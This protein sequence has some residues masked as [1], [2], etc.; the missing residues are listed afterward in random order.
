LLAILPD[1]PARRFVLDAP[2][3]R[4][5]FGFWISVAAFFFNWHR[6]ALDQSFGLNWDVL[7]S[8]SIEEQFYFLYPLLLVVCANRRRLVA[9]LAGLWGLGILASL[10]LGHFFPGQWLVLFTNSFTGFEA[11][12][13]G[14]L[15][16]VAHQAN[17][18]SG[19]DRA[20]RWIG[21]VSLVIAYTVTDLG[22]SSGQIW[23]PTWISLS[24]AALLL[25]LARWRVP[26]NNVTRLLARP[27]QLSYGI[28]LWHALAIG[29]C[30]NLLPRLNFAGES[31]L[32]MAVAWVFA[33]LSARWIEGPA[34]QRWGNHEIDPVTF[35]EV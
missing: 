34:Y 28:Y 21:A 27:G 10:V 18:W 24:A 6:I 5:D 23:G 9:V 3:S 25:G 33:A 4:R 31:A 1:S 7:W 2:G 11:I 15:V 22:R 12:A 13:L 14:C 32:V 8:L 16:F 17:F 19:H 35:V 26:D 30:W 20:L 29:L